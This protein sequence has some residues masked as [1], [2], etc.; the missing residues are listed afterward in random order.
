MITHHADN[1][2]GGLRAEDGLQIPGAP[3]IQAGRADALRCPAIRDNS[4]RLGAADEEQRHKDSD[5]N[6]LPTSHADGQRQCPTNTVRC[7]L[8]F[9]IAAS[10]RQTAV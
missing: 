9:R 2:A 6:E 3:I 8:N 10:E 7:Q 4:H 1:E 5:E